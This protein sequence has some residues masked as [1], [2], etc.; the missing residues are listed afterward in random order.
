MPLIKSKNESQVFDTITQWIQYRDKL[1]MKVFV[2]GVTNTLRP[3]TWLTRTSG[4]HFGLN[5]HDQCHLWYGLPLRLPHYPLWYADLVV[6]DNIFNSVLVDPDYIS[7]ATWC[8]SVLACIL[9]SL[10]CVD[11]QC[12]I[13]TT[14]YVVFATREFSQPF[15]IL[16]WCSLAFRSCNN[17]QHLRPPGT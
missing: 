17:G 10:I 6:N 5:W 2:S 9:S 12:S 16:D 1:W 14:L 15:L 3:L 8:E 11:V 4:F 7:R 13:L